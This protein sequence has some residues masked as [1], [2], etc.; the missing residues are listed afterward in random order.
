MSRAR[1]SGT[2]D[3][4]GHPQTRTFAEPWSETR[5][6]DFFGAACTNSDCDPRNNALII[7]DPEPEEA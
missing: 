6:E 5:D 3:V 4:C 7:R 2:C 1:Y